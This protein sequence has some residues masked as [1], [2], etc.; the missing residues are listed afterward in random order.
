MTQSSNFPTPSA[1]ATVCKTALRITTSN[2]ASNAQPAAYCCE[3]WV[4]R[5]AQYYA[6][7]PQIALRSYNQKLSNS[8]TDRETDS[9]KKTM[10][11]RRSRCQLQQTGTVYTPSVVATQSR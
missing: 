8:Q 5:A 1:R 10:M 2:A 4:Q 6:S 11:L 7:G 9:G 3:L